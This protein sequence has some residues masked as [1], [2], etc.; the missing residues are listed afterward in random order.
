[1]GGFQNGGGGGIRTH[2]TLAR[3][4][5]FKTAPI[6]RSGTPPKQIY[7]IKLFYL[8]NLNCQYFIPSAAAVYTM[9]L[10]PAMDIPRFATSH[11]KFL[12]KYPREDI[13]F[14]DTNVRQDA[15]VIYHR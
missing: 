2:G 9:V 13:P 15:V 7:R 8:L 4:T 5:V 3:S 11:N 10:I 1:M 12:P 6:N 14:P